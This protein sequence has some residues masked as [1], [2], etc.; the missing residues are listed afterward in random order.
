[1]SFAKSFET[2]E[3]TSDRDGQV[4]T[5][6][7]NRPD[8]LNA[9]NGQVL[10]D[11]HSAAEVIHDVGGIRLGVLTGAGRAFVAGADIKAMLEFSAEEALEFSRLGHGAMQ[12]I[13][14]L[15][16]PVVAAVNGYALGGG[17]ELALCCDLIYASSKA[18]LGLPEVGL[19]VI[20]GWGGTQ[21]LIRLI[22]VHHAR[23]LVY[24][25]ARVDAEEAREIG[26]VVDVLDHGTFDDELS[27]VVDTLVTRGP[28][29]LQAAK[30]AMNRGLDVPLSEGI[31]LEQE[32]FSKLFGTDDQVE[33]MKAFVE[34]RDPDFKGS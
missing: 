14:D 33:G 17:L 4:A 9:L 19:G 13:S 28:L 7:V 15:P 5:I 27:Q 32:A 6:T 1:M 18:V 25:G 29:A 10:K 16:F 20:P 30:A 26:L 21:R 22:G 23:Q 11:L 3:L 2:V 24:S 12:A 34:R 31:A 8:A